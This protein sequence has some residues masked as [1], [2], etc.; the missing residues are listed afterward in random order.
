[1]W[2]LQENISLPLIDN[3]TARG[4]YI[5]D[6]YDIFAFNQNLYGENEYA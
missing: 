6:G 3:I 5:L 1:M 2:L 4:K